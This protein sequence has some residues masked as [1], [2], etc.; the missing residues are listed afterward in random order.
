M[1]INRLLHNYLFFYKSNHSNDGIDL[2]LMF[3]QMLCLRKSYIRNCKSQFD[4]NHYDT[5][6]NDENKHL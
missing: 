2:L 1:I 3:L 6:C 4:M 5:W